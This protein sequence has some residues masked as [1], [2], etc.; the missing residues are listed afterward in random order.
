MSEKG[1]NQVRDDEDIRMEINTPMNNLK[2]G[3]ED[4]SVIHLYR[5]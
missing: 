5:K 2:G 4:D 1:E 3:L